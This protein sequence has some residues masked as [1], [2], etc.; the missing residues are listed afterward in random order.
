MSKPT[1]YSYIRFST[2]E[3]RKGDSLRRQLEASKKWA[4][5]H[6]YVLDTK[7]RDLGKSAYHGDH[8]ERGALGQFLKKVEEG[9]IPTGSVLIVE[10]FDRLSREKV[11]DALNLFT[12]VIH[13]GIKVVT[14]ADNNREYTRESIDAN[15]TELIIGLTIMSRAHEESKLKSI[16]GCEKWEEKRKQ[17]ANGGPK[18][19]KRTKGWL[20]TIG[21]RED[22]EVIEGRDIIVNRIFMER[23]KGKSPPRI[24]R[25]F[26]QDPTIT[27]KPVS[28][29]HKKECGWW[30][31]YVER[32]LKDRAVIG[33][34]QPGRWIGKQH[35]PEGPPIPNYYPAVVKEDIFYQVQATFLQ[36]TQPLKNGNGVTGMG[37]RNGSVNNLFSFIGRCGYCGDGMQLKENT[38]RVSRVK[39]HYLLCSR[40]KRKAGCKLHYVPYDEVESAV[41]RFCQGLEPADLLPDREEAESRLRT[42]QGELSATETRIS[43][44]TGKEKTLLDEIED[45]PDREERRKLRPRLRAIQDEKATLENDLPR[46]QREIEIASS[47][48]QTLQEH[49]EGLKQLL[50]VMNSLQGQKRIE[51][52]LRLRN[53][54]RR[55]IDHIEIYPEGAARIAGVNGPDNLEIHVYFHSGKF[56]YV[57][58][59]FGALTFPEGY[60]GE[61]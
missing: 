4:E 55:L 53:E 20:R 56:Q 39:T 48:G 41:L 27:W 52:R 10:S 54:I 25:E 38:A 57:Y 12:S 49:L 13:A 21:D 29:R 9:K 19:T 28:L 15:W 3:Q 7:L 40:A 22:Y 61:Y 30:P 35:V 47:A 46:I 1:A 6:G 45:T 5:A 32:I 36:N 60:D 31:G 37:G 8:L 34:G 23:L 18:L 17:A 44:L 33:E 2:P 11:L 51:L 59:G 43:I 58:P 14:L 16:R 24:A 50:D 42:I 26:N